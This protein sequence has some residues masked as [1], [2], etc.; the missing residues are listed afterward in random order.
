MT[1]TLSSSLR[2]TL[3]FDEVL[4]DFLKDSTFSKLDS[5]LSA[6]LAIDF[7]AEMLSFAR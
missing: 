5:L 2:S 3:S 7:L 4:T 6:E 1:L